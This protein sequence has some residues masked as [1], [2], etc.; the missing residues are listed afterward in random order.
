[1]S[2]TREESIAS[3]RLLVCMAKVDGVLHDDERAVLEQTFGE[4]DLPDGVTMQWLLDEPIEVGAVIAQLVGEEARDQAY[5]AVYALDCADDDCSD[6]ERA[7]LIQMRDALGIDASL[8]AHLGRLFMPRHQ[9]RAGIATPTLDAL[10]RDAEVS[11]ATRKCAIV[12]ALLGAFPIPGLSIATDLIIVGLQVGLARDIGGLWGQQLDTAQAKGVLAGFGV[13]TGA[14]I[15]LSN[16]LK[17]F[18][19]WGSAFGAA[20]AYASSY[21]VGQVMNAYFQEGRGLLADDLAARFKAAKADG[22]RAFAGDSELIE[23]QR[24]AHQTEVEAL[25]RRLAAG[26]ITADEF[27]DRIKALVA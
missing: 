6:D 16:L 18:P 24:A 22:K 4:I 3:L 12:S 20:S 27:E 19:G 10:A 14:R 15:A 8:D 13:G 25:E 21:A 7:L 23:H 1:M 17:V 5:A 9:V 11:A 2:L 26:E